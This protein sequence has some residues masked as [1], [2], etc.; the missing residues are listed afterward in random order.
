MDLPSSA[1]A[2]ASP[3]AGKKQVDQLQSY[4]W[5]A[6]STT[7]MRAFGTTACLRAR[8]VVLVLVNQL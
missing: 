6:G 4:V 5:D 7:R 8:V 3:A 2:T 1:A